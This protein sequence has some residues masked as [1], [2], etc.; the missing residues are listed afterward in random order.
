MERRFSLSVKLRLKRMGGTNRPFYRLVAIDSRKQRD[1]R[2]I[3]ELGYYDPLRT[4][5]TAQ[6]DEARLLQWLER[7]AEPSATVRRLLQRGG[8]LE[9]WQLLR[10]G[11]SAEEATQR[12]GARLATRT[13]KKRKPRLSKKAKSKAQAAAA[14]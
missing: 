10:Q 14:S 6:L 1:G 7:G 11:L 2:F 4:P 3:Q 13:E 8:V 9:K 12:V 5:A